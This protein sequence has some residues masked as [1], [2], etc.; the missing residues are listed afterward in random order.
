MSQLFGMDFLRMQN[1]QAVNQMQKAPE[2]K[3]EGITNKVGNPKISDKAS[4]YYEKLKEK[5]G[6][7]EFVVVDDESSMD[8]KEYAAN[9]TSDKEM[10]VLISESELE[11]MATDET[12]RA[13][14]EQW[15]ADAREQM[16]QMAKKLEESGTKV[17]AFGMEFNPDGT[18]TYFAV[19][20][21][22]FEAST[23]EE[24]LKKLQDKAL[25][26]KSDNVLTEQEKLVGQHFD[27]RF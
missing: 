16:P 18:P 7:V 3:N 2:K 25:E 9:S 11:A 1:G 6:D 24:L 27:Y 26:A 17:E 19:T 5:Y 13:R 23:L 21:E 15:I 14:N 10:F 22:T 12:V 4:E 8:A 20:E